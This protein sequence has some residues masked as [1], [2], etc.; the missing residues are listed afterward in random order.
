MSFEKEIVPTD[1]IGREARDL[2]ARQTEE[3][4]TLGCIP[5]RMLRATIVIR[6]PVRWYARRQEYFFWIS[7]SVNVTA[8]ITAN[9]RQ[10]NVPMRNY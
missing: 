10:E 4:S 6:R 8:W 3:W 9:L 7:P 5:P 2:E 1:G